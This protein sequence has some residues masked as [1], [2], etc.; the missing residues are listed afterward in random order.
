[1]EAVNKG[2]HYKVSLMCANNIKAMAYAG[3]LTSSDNTVSAVKDM[4][5]K[6]DSRQLIKN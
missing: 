2:V 4:I 1:M 3:Y 5:D 6:S